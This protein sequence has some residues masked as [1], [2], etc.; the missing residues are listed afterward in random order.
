MSFFF[1]PKKVAIIGAT[2]HPRK[3][4][5]V[6]TENILSN[7]DRDYDV[8]LVSLKKQQINGLETYQSILDINEDI[9]VAI[10]LV[11]ARAVEE[12]V[13]NCIK[14]QVKGIIIVTGGFG[15]IN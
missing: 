12:V 15:E 11:P 9:D 5:N 2:A 7:K 14:K 8:F 3:F 1:N 13:D 4:G 10:I 6:V